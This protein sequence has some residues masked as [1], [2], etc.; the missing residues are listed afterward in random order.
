MRVNYGQSVHGAEEIKA[1]VK[2][3]K[4]STQ[5]GKNVFELEK[6]IS[7]LFSKKYGVMVNSGSSALMLAFEILNFKKNDEV[8]TPVLT[9]S[10]T[11]TSIVKNGLKPIFVDVVANTFCIDI[12]KIEK[13]INKKTRAICV[14][15]LIGNLPNWKEIKKI[16]KKYNLILIEDSADTVGARILNKPSGFYSDIS[17]TSFYGSHIINGAGNGGMLCLNNFKM[18]KDALLLRSWGRSSSIYKENSEKI[19]NR[20]NI[21][22][23]KIEY[24]KKFVFEKM[25]YNLEGSELSAAFALVQLKKLNN[26]IKIRERNFNLHLEFFKKYREF[27]VLPKQLPDSKT[28]WL[29]FPLIIKDSAKFKRK[30]LQIYLEKKNIQTRVVFTGNI[31]KQPGFSFLKKD[32]KEYPEADFVMRGGILIGC[33]QGL[34]NKHINYM[35]KNFREFLKINN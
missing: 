18:Y 24:D 12:A 27:F 32:N 13:L 1:V 29:A 11:V 2:V 33:H 28:A 25:G 23:N 26:L 17:I 6:K 10:S 16:S 9:F 31:L 15:N 22:L 8:I 34:N 5:M 4:T 14:P 21:K 7:W 19:E 20:F 3:L 30:D 35:H